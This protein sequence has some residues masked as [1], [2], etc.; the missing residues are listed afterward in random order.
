[1]H[2][3]WASNR[4]I[5]GR[6]SLHLKYKKWLLIRRALSC[7]AWQQD[8]YPPSSEM[9]CDT[10]ILRLEDIQ[11]GL[12]NICED[13]RSRILPLPPSTSDGPVECLS[14]DRYVWKSRLQI[15][16]ERPVILSRLFV[17]FFNPSR[18]M[19]RFCPKLDH[20]HFVAVHNSLLNNHAVNRYHMRTTEGVVK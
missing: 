18:Q 12:M 1:M 6:S 17:R 7:V 5:T 2:V 13:M 10:E 16:V 19:L 20:G 3:S 15:S 11:R 4:G 9:S 14:S 8:A